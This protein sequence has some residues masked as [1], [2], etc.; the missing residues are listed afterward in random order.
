M[1]APASCEMCG[2][3]LD[4]V[5]L[6]C[7]YCGAERQAAG[8]PAHRPTVRTVNLEKGLPTVE[9]ALIRLR[10]EIAQGR[11]LGYRVLVLIHG[12]GSSG[13]GGAIREEVRRLLG[14]LRDNR[15]INDFLAGEQCDRRTGHGR[16]L[17][18][19]FPFL[20]KYLQTPNPGISLVVL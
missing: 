4:S 17:A 9:Q 19:R 5:V 2:N 16:Q 20:A 6:R 1:G 10:H 18:R 3:D 12:Y 11:A 13:E 8:Q 15:Q 14:S 7:P